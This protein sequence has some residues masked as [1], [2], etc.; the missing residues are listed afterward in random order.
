MFQI[1]ITGTSYRD[2]TTWSSHVLMCSCASVLTPIPDVP[3]LTPQQFDLSEIGEFIIMIEEGL[4]LRER[5]W[6]TPTP[7]HHGSRQKII[8]PGVRDSSLGENERFVTR[9]REELRY[10]NREK[11]FPDSVLEMLF[12]LGQLH[13][14]EP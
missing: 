10:L 14:V 5:D 13:G 3:S 6:P 4:D 11:H 9:I 7:H 8:E 12:Q 1:A 2:D